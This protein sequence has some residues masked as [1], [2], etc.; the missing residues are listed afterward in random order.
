MSTQS[1]ELKMS[2]TLKIKPRRGQTPEDAAAE[3]AKL[4]EQYLTEPTYPF[5]EDYGPGAWG[6]TTAPPSRA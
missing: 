4:F 5:R 3:F 2:V 1:T 6:G